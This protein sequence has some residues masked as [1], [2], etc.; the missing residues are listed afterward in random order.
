M[1][2]VREHADAFTWFLGLLD[3]VGSAP[4]GKRV[5][6]C[7]GHG[8]GAPSLS[9]G[10]GEDG[11]VLLR[12][13]AGCDA[14]KVLAALKCPMI[15][16][17]EPGTMAPVKFARTFCTGLEFPELDVRS[18]G[19]PKARGYRFEG[20]HAY[21]DRWW[22]VRYRHPTTRAKD[23]MWES[24]NPKGERVPGLLGTPT[25]ALPAYM[26]TEARRAV[27]MGEPVL[28][29]ESESSVDALTKAGWYATTWAGGA[30]SVKLQALGKVLE[31]PESPRSCYPQTVVIPD[32]D[33]PGLAALDVLRGAGMAPHV[34]MGEPKEDA[35]DLLT[36]LGADEFRALIEQA[37]AR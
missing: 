27:F 3:A 1:T 7:P 33:E 34:V 24:L 6:Q 20:E 31:D 2:T 23:L 8:D 16:L 19:G 29:V 11:R 25:E 12:C 26:A 10:R 21:G 14:R 9:I 15:R 28:V 22:L 30:T 5:R 18:G 4:L 36:R 37:L 32:N 35:K 17:F 13:H